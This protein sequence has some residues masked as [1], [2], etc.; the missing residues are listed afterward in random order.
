LNFTKYILEKYSNIKFNENPS[1][2]SRR[3]LADRRRQMVGETDIKKVIVTFCNFT[4]TPE[5]KSV[6]FVQGNYLAMLWE[7]HKIHKYISLAEC[8]LFTEKP[9]G[10]YSNDWTLNAP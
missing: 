3:F 9:V 1:I 6:D 8:R 4:N 7:L 2:W 5:N 10:L